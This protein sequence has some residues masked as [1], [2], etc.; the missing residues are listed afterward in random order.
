[1]KQNGDG[2]SEEESNNEAQRRRSEER[3][4]PILY[5][6][7]RHCNRNTEPKIQKPCGS[8]VLCES[9]YLVLVVK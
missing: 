7:W 5:R 4:R 3:M 9:W 2:D 1:M 8:R 6:R